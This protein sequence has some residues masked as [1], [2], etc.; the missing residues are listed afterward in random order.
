VAGPESNTT[1]LDDTLASFERFAQLATPPER[2]EGGVLPALHALFRRAFPVATDEA[3][4]E[5]VSYSLERP[6]YDEDECARRGMTWAAPLKLTVR[7]I[8]WDG[9]ADEREFRDIKE[10]E[11]YFGEVPLMTERGT[12]VVDGMERV[13]VTRAMSL[14]SDGPSGSEG[15]LVRAGDWLSHACL[16]GLTMTLEN[17]GARMGG[18]IETLMPHDVLNA[19]PM[20]QA[21]RALFEDPRRCEAALARNPVAQVEHVLG[22]KDEIAIPPFEP[23]RFRRRLRWE[24]PAIAWAESGSEVLAPFVLDPDAARSALSEARVLAEPEVA[25]VLTGR[26]RAWA[27][28]AGLLRLAGVDGRLVALSSAIVIL[29]EGGAPAFLLTPRA[30]APS[31]R[32]VVDRLVREDGPVSALDVVFESDGARDGQLAL[33]RNARVAF[34]PTLQGAVVSERFARAARSIDTVVLEVARKD[35]RDGM[36]ERVPAGG[37]GSGVAAL[38]TRVRAGDVLVGISAPRRDRG[39]RDVS[40][41]VGKKTEGT[42]VHVDIFARR[43]HERSARHQALVDAGERP[44][45][46]IAELARRPD[47]DLRLQALADERPWQRGDDLAPGV[48]ELTRVTI[49][50]EQPLTVGARLV[51]RRGF[52]APIV[53]IDADLDVDVLFPGPPPAPALREIEEGQTLYLLHLPAARVQSDDDE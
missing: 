16:E 43:G 47:A 48:I 9:P 51:D 34:D 27:R 36:Q 20:A 2:R 14:S 26:E 25:R 41:R 15:Q 44:W 37:D 6:R 50:R 33:G 45:H 5:Y 13:L 40:L 32:R 23:R 46:E 42:V 35:T 3:S 30:Y 52:G 39:P 24:E 31:R 7:L 21:L 17:A 10:Q 11:V 19:K 49:E 29:P 22:V 53:R 38:G 12:F 1:V 28:D 8:I 18:T 4:L